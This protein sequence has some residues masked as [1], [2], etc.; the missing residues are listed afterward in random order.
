MIRLKCLLK[1]DHIEAH[2][3]YSLMYFQASGFDSTVSPIQR[4]VGK[5]FAQLSVAYSNLDPFL[6]TIKLLDR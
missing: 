5:T 2:N 4:R 6:C 3:L 1:I